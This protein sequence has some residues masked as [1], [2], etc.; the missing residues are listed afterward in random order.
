MKGLFFF[1]SRVDIGSISAALSGPWARFPKQRLAEPRVAV[2]IPDLQALLFK[3]QQISA[4]TS[5]PFRGILFNTKLLKFWCHSSK[6][7]RLSPIFM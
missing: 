2:L 3:A 6:S 7:A 5:D 4:L 1:S